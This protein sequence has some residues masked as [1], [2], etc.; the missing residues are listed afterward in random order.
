M[1]Y[2]AR[3]LPRPKLC[4][5]GLTP[6]AQRLVPAAALATVERRVDTA[7]LEAPAGVRVRIRDAEASVAMVERDRFDHA[8]AAAAADAG[9]VVRDGEPVIDLMADERSVRLVT[10]NARETADV[11]LLADGEPGRLA[12]RVG[13]ASRPR[14]RALA[15]EVDLPFGPG[16]PTDAAIV[17]FRVPG[18][19]AWCFP[20]G[21]HVNVGLAAETRSVAPLREALSR[22]ARHLGLDP[23]GGRLRGHWIPVGL[24]RGP[25]ARG[26]VLLLGDAAAA[27]DPFFGEGIAYAVASATI[28]A[29]A[30]GAWADRSADLCA[31]DTAVRAALAPLHE[32]LDATARVVRLA[33]PAAVLA[34][35][36]WPAVLRAAGDVVVGRG[37]WGLERRIESARGIMW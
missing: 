20:K 6:K 25:L 32:R 26:R 36:Y 16:T 10:A 18:G 8:L 27:A 2:E 29:D 19:Y 37:R 35:R 12:R 7:V 21:D 13:L 22:F 28:A 9:A 34:V 24:R 23:A 30:V 3:R 14:G 11:V 33:A 4:G 31:Y 1:L 5:G 17:S 15:L